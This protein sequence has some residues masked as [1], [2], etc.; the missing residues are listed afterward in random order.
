MNGKS[1]ARNLAA[2]LLCFLPGCGNLFEDNGTHLAYALERGVETLR[3][4]N[5]PRL[6]VRYQTLDGG[7]NPYYIE[8]TP[9]FNPGQ[10]SDIPGSYLV[11]SGKS[12]GGTSYHNRFV[13]VP[14]RL[15][16]EKIQ[17]G[18]AELVL[19]RD[20]SGSISLIELR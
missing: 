20:A 17:G 7:R 18:S 16:V 15:Y 14:Q 19:Q 13:L 12:R 9:S 5:A 11:V 2:T 4:S 6:V 10:P 1:V 8:I 3:A